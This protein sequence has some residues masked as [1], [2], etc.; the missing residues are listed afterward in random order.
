MKRHLYEC[1]FKNV[2]N[3]CEDFYAV[4]E[5]DNLP[6]HD[7][8]VTNPPYSE[9]AKG[10]PNHI[11][12]LLKWCTR[13]SVPYLLNMPEYVASSGFYRRR[14]NRHPPSPLLLCPYRRY[15]FWTP[16]GLRPETNVKGYRNPE[17][18]Y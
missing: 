6:D 7:V 1:G 14:F 9:A 10:G 11:E 16:M 12:R 4:M 13:R 2:Y 8:V 18:G 3:E 5:A 15:S 17:L